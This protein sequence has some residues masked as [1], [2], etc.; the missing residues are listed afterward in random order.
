MSRGRER[1]GRLKE[2]GVTLNEYFRYESLG[3][4]ESWT[5]KHRA[6]AT[7]N[8]FRN[9]DSVKKMQR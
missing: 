5:S 7:E 1:Y 3:T 6:F 8:F 9:N 2:W 4:M